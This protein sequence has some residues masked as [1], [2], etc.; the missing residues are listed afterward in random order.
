LL[1]VGLFQVKSPELVVASW[2]YYRH[3]RSFSAT[4]VFRARRGGVCPLSP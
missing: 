2:D 4:D 3:G 1:D